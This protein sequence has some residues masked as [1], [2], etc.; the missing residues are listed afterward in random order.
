MEE[1]HEDIFVDYEQVSYK[2]ETELFFRNLPRYTQEYVVGLLPIATWI[3]RY[4][5]TVSFR[6]MKQRGC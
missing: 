5:L 4:N 2:Q 1:K 6:Q 3:G